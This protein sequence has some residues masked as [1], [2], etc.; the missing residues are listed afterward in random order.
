MF[1]SPDRENREFNLQKILKICFYAG[2]LPPILGQSFGF[3]AN[4]E[5]ETAQKWNAVFCNKLCCIWDCGLNQRKYWNHRGNRGNFVLI[6]LLQ[7][8]IQVWLYVTFV[9]PVSVIFTVIIGI[10]DTLH[11]NRPLQ[12][13]KGD[14]EFSDIRTLLG[15]SLCPC[16]ARMR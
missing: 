3:V 6:R 13:R 4:F 10:M 9:Y 5:L 12:N 2:N 7:P 15:S 11:V 14:V 1:I 16:W 8:R